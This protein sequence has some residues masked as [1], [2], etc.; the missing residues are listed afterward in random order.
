ML[1]RS[2]VPAS[3]AGAQNPGWESLIA[4]CAGV[5]QLWD[6]APLGFWGLAAWSC[7]A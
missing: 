6:L 4:L 2:D 7:A 5:W 3:R 1:S